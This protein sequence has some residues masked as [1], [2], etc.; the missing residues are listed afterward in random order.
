MAEIQAGRLMNPRSVPEANY[1]FAQEAAA[2]P[3]SLPVN[4]LVVDDDAH[5]R[6]LCRSVAMES[7]MKVSDVST[8]EEALEVTCHRIERQR[9]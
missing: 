4:L 8:A 1:V 3:I 9:R 2:K 7:G 6:E 5:V